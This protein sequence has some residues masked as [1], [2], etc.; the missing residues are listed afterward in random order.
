[1]V[2]LD[3]GWA[4]ATDDEPPRDRAVARP[5]AIPIAT[6]VIGMAAAVA[7]GVLLA[8][9]HVEMRKRDVGAGLHARRPRVGEKEQRG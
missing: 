5:R 9:H 8:P 1:M 6:G 2:R 4:T 3:G 7:L